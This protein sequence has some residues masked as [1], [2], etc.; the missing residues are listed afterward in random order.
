MRNIAGKTVVLTGASGG[1][2]VYIARALAKEQV[3]LVSISRSQQGLDRICAEI[4]ATG[5]K[6]ISISFD[7]QKL[8]ELPLLVEKITKF[9]GH[10]D[11]LINNAAIEKF[12]SFHDY[13]LQDIQSILTTNLLAAMELTRLVLPS[14]LGRNNGHIVNIASGSGKKGAPYNS[15]YS[16]SKAG[17]IMWSDAIRQELA[18]TNIGVSAICPGYTDAGMFRALGVSA[19]N[20]MRVAQPTEVA[21][22]VLQSIKQNQ[23]EVILDGTSS[24]IFSAITQL[25]PQF[26]DRIFRQLGVVNLN[27][28][29]AKKQMQAENIVKN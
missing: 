12:R 20:G 22:A 19:P 16:A 1:I 18:D 4:K 24:K 5:S 17:L 8:E 2:G 23:K 15:I 14:M 21:N 6:G 9:A 10:I 7:I 13:S 26:G 29:C 25:S 27:Q 11:I 3:N 28:N